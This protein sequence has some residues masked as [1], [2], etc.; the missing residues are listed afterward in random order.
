ML[1]MQ[2]THIPFQ[3]LAGKIAKDFLEKG[4]SL[5]DGI[6]AVAKQRSL[7]PEEVKR[8]VEKSNTA[9][10]ILYLKNSEDKKGSFALAKKD[11]V[12]RRTHPAAETGDAADEDAREAAVAERTGLPESRKVASFKAEAEPRSIEKQAAHKD[13]LTVHDVLAAHARVDELRQLK[14]AA[15]MGLEDILHDIIREY[16]YK[17]ASELSKLASEAAALYGDGAMALLKTA[18]DYLRMPLTLEKDACIIDDS[19]KPMRMLKQAEDLLASM[20]KIA[21]ALSSLEQALTVFSS[22]GTSDDHKDR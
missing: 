19:T 7:K 1:V 8:L 3:D 17:D 10:S 6:V 13:A 20:P 5:E 9:A 11:E 18:A 14:V 22:K 16:Q 21:Q 4:A 15:A 2:T 12:L